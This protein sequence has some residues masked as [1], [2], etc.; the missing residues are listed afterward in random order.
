MVRP[1]V[2]RGWTKTVMDILLAMKFQRGLH[3][4]TDSDN[5]MKYALLL[6]NTILSLIVFAETPPP[7]I[8][9]ILA[10]DMGWTGIS[11]QS[12]PKRPDSKSHRH[13]ASP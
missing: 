12:H 4:G 11:V 3:L 1:T 5:F 6:L 13:Y 8:V 7:N 10:D 9:F 2:S